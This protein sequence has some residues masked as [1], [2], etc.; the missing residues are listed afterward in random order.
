MLNFDGLIACICFHIEKF[1][2]SEATEDLIFM[3]FVSFI[4]VFNATGILIIHIT[5]LCEERRVR[6]EILLPLPSCF[7]HFSFLSLT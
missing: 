6:G 7:F 3:L 1:L 2:L 4:Q 5:Y